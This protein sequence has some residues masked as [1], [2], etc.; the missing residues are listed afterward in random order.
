MIDGN[1]RISDGHYHCD[2]TSSAM[3]CGPSAIPSRA[4]ACFGLRVHVATA[5]ASN[6]RNVA[7]KFQYDGDN[8]RTYFR[9]Y[10]KCW[11]L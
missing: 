5:S 8:G 11:T 9:A 6:K 4:D 3:Y 7:R 2:I 1:R 10:T